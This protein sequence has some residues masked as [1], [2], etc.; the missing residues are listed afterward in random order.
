MAHLVVPLAVVAAPLAETDW[1]QWRGPAR[2]GQATGVAWGESL[3]T[4]HLQQLWRVPLG[5]SYSGPV[6]VGDRV[7][8]TETKDKQ[9]EIVRAF[10]RSTG[11]ELW[12]VSWEGALSVP[13]FAKSNGDWIRATPASD[14]EHLYVAGMRD[15]LVCLS[16]ATGAEKWRVDFVKLLGAPLPDFGFVS[17]PL[18]DGDGVYAQA[19]ASVVK[20]NKATGEVVWR[21]LQDQGG[22]WGSAFSSPI[23]ATL[24]GQR[25][26]VVQTRSE[27]AGL[28]P[29]TGKVLWTQ[30]I[31][32]F[33]GMNIL[34]PVVFGDTLFTSTYGGRTAAYQVSREAGQFKLSEIWS[35]KSQGNMTTPVVV[36][37]YAYHH[38]R[39]QRA[40]C[41]DL[42]T[43]EERWMTDRGFGK[44]WSLVANGD[45]ILALDDRGILFLLRAN[46]E[47]FEVMDQRKL[48]EADTWAHLAVSGRDLF[49]RELNGLTA[50]RFD[51]PPAVA[52][53]LTPQ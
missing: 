1:P 31:E 12:Q 37:P 47:K 30:P 53:N 29:A 7:F 48:G 23:L 6:V 24:A 46:P 5:P 18:V 45:R 22:M 33:R 19:G 34:T 21:A 49:V 44:Y 11:R 43:G 50:Y 27:L 41:L 16:V 38:L 8:T 26:L 17:S 2:D 10:D 51:R 40:L 14:G 9:T 32:A 52:P 25:Q 35:H 15:V 42:R 4:D 36:G 28:D 3:Q 39:N 13:F 20:L